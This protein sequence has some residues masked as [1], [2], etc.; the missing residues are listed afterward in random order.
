MSLTG[1]TELAN[2]GLNLQAVF[3]LCDLPASLLAQL[4]DNASREFTQLLLFAHGGRRLWEVLNH[5]EKQTND[6]IDEF[7]IHILEFHLFPLYPQ[8]HFEVVFPGEHIIDLQ[9]L[10]ELAGWHHASPFMVGIN[11]TWGT[12]F[13]YRAV[14]LANTQ[15]PVTV[16]VAETS[17]CSVC[18]TKD[19]KMACAGKAVKPDCFEISSCLEYRKQE[20]S[21]CKDKCLS[22]LACPVASEHRY[23]MEQINYHYKVSLKTILSHY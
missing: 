11:K 21:L 5:S 12:W 2:S 20:N 18:F 6:P 19:C 8:H 1:A 9:K 15:L 3:N 7:A 4:P 23:T 16:P 13:A 10:G 17:P 14:V 22:R